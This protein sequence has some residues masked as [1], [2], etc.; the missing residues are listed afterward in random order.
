M[1]KLNEKLQKRAALVTNMRKVLNLADSEKRN[2]TADETTKYEAYEADILNLDKEIRREQDLEKLEGQINFVPDSQFKPN[3]NGDAPVNKLAT[4]EYS[5]AFFNGY[6]RKGINGMSPD[7]TNA[8]EV[9]TN[10]EGGYL[11]PQEWA[12]SLI[13]ALPE[14]VVMRRYA[15]VIVTASDRNIPIETS[16]GAFTW[17]DEE[18]AYGTNDPVFGNI[19]LSAHKVGG[20]VKVSEEL[21]QDNVYNLEGRLRQMAM[22]EFADKEED[23]F[24]N[25]DDSGKP[26]GVFQTTTVGGVSVTGTTGAVSAT[27]AITFDNIIDTYYG[28]ARKYRTNAA[29]LASDGHAKLI[30]KLKDSDGQYLWQPSL[31]AGEP[32]RLLNRPFEVSDSAPAPATATRGLCFGDWRYYTIVDRL[33]MVAQRLNELYAA[34]GQIGFKFHKRIDGGMTLA[35]AMTFFAHGAAS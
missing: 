9:G 11:V 13:T 6:M 4:K 35:P 22:E 21:L 23:A 31:V 2:L 12:Q 7:Y 24:V 28:L 30:R 5:N 34:N 8:L 10:S 26:E 25:G 27:A 16:R 14:L 18:G 29:W 1:S 17:I 32:D 19:V 20:I 33:N 15:E 3:P